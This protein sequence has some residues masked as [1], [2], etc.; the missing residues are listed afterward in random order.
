M[1]IV[2]N[3]GDS[4]QRIS[5]PPLLPVVRC[6]VTMG[7]EWT[8]RLLRLGVL[9]RPI[10]IGLVGRLPLFLPPSFAS[11]VVGTAANRRIGCCRIDYSRDWY[12]TRYVVIP[13]LIL[14][15]AVGDG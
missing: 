3:F 15:A 9:V 1:V 6:L 11:T 2:V 8:L 5:D 4:N 10:L 14:G 13:N 12:N 7:R